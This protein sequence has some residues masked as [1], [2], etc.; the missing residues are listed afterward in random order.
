MLRKKP[1]YIPN[2]HKSTR[3]IQGSFVQKLCGAISDT[4]KNGASIE[5]LDEC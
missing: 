4:N 3:N 1:I 5:T 2:M